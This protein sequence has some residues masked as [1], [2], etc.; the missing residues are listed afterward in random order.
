MRQSRTTV[1]RALRARMRTCTYEYNN[2]IIIQP[3]LPRHDVIHAHALW[4]WHWFGQIQRE[5][6]ESGQPHACVC[7]HCATN[8]QY[9]LYNVLM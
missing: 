6:P 8:K 4:G 5:P 2:I 9:T 3:R 7:S 1:A